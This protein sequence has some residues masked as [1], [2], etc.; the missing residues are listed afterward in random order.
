MGFEFEFDVVWYTIKVGKDKLNLIEKT[1]EK[2][3][4]K[5]SVFLEHL[6]PLMIAL[7]NTG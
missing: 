6:G 5:V 7:R 1:K 2:S 4:N 3:S